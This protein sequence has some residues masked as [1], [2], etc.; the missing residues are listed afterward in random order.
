M[1]TVCYPNNKSNIHVP[2]SVVEAR[3]LAGWINS[4]S[5]QLAISRL[6]SSTTIGPTT[7]HRLPIPKFDPEDVSHQRIAEIASNLEKGA[8]AHELDE[9]VK[10]T[11]IET[12]S[13]TPLRTG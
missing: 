4:A 1:K 6:A 5:A 13:G 8:L 11:V 2:N 10:S 3:Y 7:L 12:P 9:L